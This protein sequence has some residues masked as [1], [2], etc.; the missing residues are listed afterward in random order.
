MKKIFTFVMAI[1]LTAMG[2]AQTNPPENV[3]VTP[4]SYS[5]MKI[6]WNVPYGTTQPSRLNLYN[7]ADLVTRPG[8]GY[9]GADVSATYGGQTNYGYN[10]T[11]HLDNLDNSFWIADDFTLNSSAVV[12][13]IDFFAYATGSTITSEPFTGCYVRIYDTQPVDSTAVPVW[14][15]GTV[16]CME[17]QVWSGIYRTTASAVTNTDRPIMRITANINA[18]L[19]AGTYW[20]AVCFTASSTPWMAPRS[21]VSELSTGNAIQ[22]NTNTGLWNA[23]TDNTSLEQMGIPFVVRGEFVSENLSG[24]KVYRDNVLADTALIE[25]FSFIDTGLFENT[26][27]C[28]SVEAIYSTGSPAMS[29]QE[30]TTTPEAPVD[31]CTLSELPYVQSFDGYTTGTGHFEV[32]CWNRFYTTTSTSYPYLATTHHSGNASVYMNAS[33]TNYSFI[34]APPLLSDTMVEHVTI[35]FWMKKSSATSAAAIQ[36]GVMTDPTDISTFSLIT[37]FTP[38]A[39]TDWQEA[40]IDLAGN[41]APGA[42]IT[43]K[44]TGALSYV[45]DFGIFFT[46]CMYPSTLEVMGLSTSSA[47]IAWNS[48]GASSYDFSY[49]LPLDA[50]WTDVRD[51][52]DTVYTITGLDNATAYTFD[53]RVRPICGSDMYYTSSVSFVTSCLP[54][55]APMVE[56]FEGYTAGSSGGYPVPLCWYKA[57]SVP[58]SNYPYINSS[59]TNAYSGNNYIYLYSY[60]TSTYGDN[61]LVLPA[62]TNPLNSL[63]L[64]FMARESS[65]TASY[66]GKIYVGIVT[67][68]VD[69]STFIPVDTIEPTTTTYTLFETSFAQYTGP[70]GYIAMIAPKPTTGYN[71]IYLDNL[72]VAVAGCSMPENLV[73]TQATDNSITCSWEPAAG[74]SAV[75]YTLAYLNADDPDATWVE[76]TGISDTTYT[77]MNLDENTTY[78]VKVKMLCA[79]GESAYSFEEEFMTLCTERMQVPYEENF[80]NYASLSYMDCWTRPVAYVSS[81]TLTYPSVLNSASSAHSGTNSLRFSTKNAWAATPAIDA[82]IEDLTLSF[83]A[84][85]AATTSGNMEVGVMSNPLDTST[86]ELVY[87]VTSPTTGTYQFVE[88]R[89][90]SVQTNGLNRHIAFRLN[91]TA[92]GM[93]YIDDINL[94]LTNDCPR[95]TDVTFTNITT[96]SATASW[97]TDPDVAAWNLRVKPTY[98]ETEWIEYNNLTT[99]SCI[100]TDL[101]PSTDYTVQ[102]QA[103][104]ASLSYDSYWSIDYSFMTECGII[105]TLP[106]TDNFDSYG[107]G[108]SAHPV[109]WTHNCT[110]TGTYN[111]YPYV[112]TTNFSAPASLY[113]NS[114]VQ[115]GQYDYTYFSNFAATPRIDND[116]DISA[117]AATFRLYATSTSYWMQIGFMTDSMDINTF[118]PFDTLRVSSTSTWEEKSIEFTNYTGAGRFLAFKMGGVNSTMTMYIDN[119]VLDYIPTCYKPIDFMVDSL[120]QTSIG[121]SWT[122]A[123]METQW[124]IA[125]K[126]DT[127]SVWIPITGIVD[128]FY[129]IDNLLANTTYQI[130]IKSVCGAGDESDYTDI[131]T[132]TT[133]CYALTTLPYTESFDNGAMSQTNLPMCWNKYYSGTVSNYPYINTAAGNVNTP[134]GALYMYA[135]TTYFDIAILPELDATINLSDLKL[136]F[137]AKITTAENGVQVGVMDNPL[138]PN[139]FVP[140]QTVV[141]STTSVWEDMDVYFANYTGNGHF[142][143]IKVG[144]RTRTNTVRI[145]DLVL[146]IAEPCY[147]P[148]DVTVNSISSESVEIGWYSTPNISNCEYVIGEPGFVPDTATPMSFSNIDNTIV[149]TDLQPNTSYT[150]YVRNI[151]PGGSPS[152]WSYACNFTTTCTPYQVPYI[153]D[154]D[155]DDFGSGS[156][157]EC[158]NKVGNGTLYVNN[159][160]SASYIANYLYLYTTTSTS[161]YAVL[162]EIDADINLLQLNFFAKFSNI[163][164]FFEVGIMSNP[165]DT[166]TFEYIETVN[167]RTTVWNE[168]HIPFTAYSGT[169]KFIAIRSVQNAAT[170][171]IDN[172]SVTY[173]PGCVQP[174]NIQA[175]DITTTSVSLKWR[176]GSGETQWEVA[177]GPEGFSPD[178][179]VG[180]ATSVNAY[181]DSIILTGLTPGTY[182]DV[183]VRSVCGLD[184]QSAW[185]QVFT[186]RTDCLP[187]DT[188]PYVE[189]FS[190]VSS[191]SYPLV[192]CWERKNTYSATIMYPYVSSGQLYFVSSDASYSYATT[193]PFSAN[194]NTLQVLF[195]YKAS[196][197]DYFLVVGVMSDPYDVTTFVPVDTVSSN[198]SS[199]YETKR[200][201]FNQYT[202]DGHHIAFYSHTSTYN[203]IYLD[204]V[205]VSEIPSC[206]DPEDLAATQV[207]NNSVTLNWNDPLNPTPSGYGYTV[208]YAEAGMNTYSY[209]QNVSTPPY[210]VTGLQSGTEY[211]FAV[212]R[213]CNANDSSNYSEPII[214]QTTCDPLSIPY[215]EDFDSINTAATYLTSGVLPDCWHGY[216]TLDNPAWQPHVISRN[217][218]TSY[219][220][221]NTLPNCL[222]LQANP[223]DST[224]VAL[225][226]FDQPLSNISVSFAK[227]MTTA[228]ASY[229]R[230]EV[231]YTTDPYDIDAFVSVADIVPVTSVTIDSVSFQNVANA[232]AGARIAFKWVNTYTTSTTMSYRCC[233]DDI[234]VRPIEVCE[235]PTNLSSSNITSNSATISW[236]ANGASQWEVNHKTSATSDWTTTI[237]NVPNINLT[238]LTAQTSYDVR[239]RALCNYGQ[240]P[241]SDVLTFTAEDQIVSCPDP[242]NLTATE[243]T[244]NS[245]VLEWTENG[246]ANSWI[247]NYQA[248]GENGW[249][250]SQTTD[251]PCVLTGL[252]SETTYSVFVV[253]NCETAQS[254]PSN[255]V[256]FTTLTNDIAE[257]DLTTT[258]Y[259]NPNNGR[260]IIGN[261][262][263]NIIDVNVYD[264]YGR[265]MKTVDVN[266]N[267]TEIDVSEL[268]SGIY[269][270]RI[271]TENGVV[272]KSFVKK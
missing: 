242:T 88:I 26:T 64:S 235:Q 204:N 29:S 63:V 59:T 30:C 99:N 195:D 106:F 117:L 71:I 170:V 255:T 86:F 272:T 144:D 34:V 184:E 19:A 108:S 46:D 42:Y 212:L 230:L 268:S 124:E 137:K 44:A 32:P 224:I 194:I 31:P 84:D 139:S 45:D 201:V 248:Q 203:Y 215:L 73:Q 87:T 96:T 5:Q 129:T 269:F 127:A 118:V 104:C 180:G 69:F 165:S 150:F 85:K 121:L 8:A 43:L 81:A 225:P 231:G 15:S 68:P 47:T 182:Y 11:A 38:Q 93:Y 75:S 51:I 219:A 143:A 140:V 257:Y 223:T 13:K 250:V 244:H 67:D 263:Y 158:W 36:V 253:S 176:N 141:P 167:A 142:I 24:F 234:A 246:T 256:S 200:V 146:D 145:D 152:P 50:D 18:S 260:F 189:D 173:A 60:S 105:S 259:P 171:Y 2:F 72:V 205:E 228:T 241:W 206:F 214:V 168:F 197:P 247:I 1:C 130:K 186:F 58:T 23:L 131:I 40:V 53:V 70:N 239:V 211:E 76:I 209:I 208:R 90:D 193:P 162:P 188:L 41:T 222:L 251:N 179:L 107:T 125:Y 6:T 210:T 261:E 128:T 157:P 227:R 61:Y 112:A 66:V 233:I 254:G 238:A 218:S 138:D 56:D 191:G 252:Q 100:I 169:G 163:N 37:T 217:A 123:N 258:L 74:S 80:D 14:T 267:S 164:Y 119:F 16:S 213:N 160:A 102:V 198:L 82:N 232:P 178:V 207:S 243:M 25:G 17:S 147:R 265:L 196:S 266:G 249:S 110:N 270:A 226:E 113:F 221:P 94:N 95:P 92:S 120:T 174:A 12:S 21:I 77:M 55:T 54:S 4:L 49:K 199:V 133:L 190:N 7:Q 22:Y 154:F 48:T 155:S 245:V 202:G 98:E 89:F 116:I 264:V 177:Y 10:A 166:S 20:V 271:T 122:P 109:C 3:T 78:K 103:Q 52:M 135:T 83:W 236:D 79:N 35:K 187:I 156:L 126:E 62:F 183:Y 132:S 136:S 192:H 153:H 181:E 57:N 28:Y 114:G 111:Y 115:S 91:T 185:S 151:C 9:E 220:Y 149:L 240:S 229:V 262:K 175:T 161:S 159:T 39:N 65:T 216:S 134:P 97:P 237:V 148:L 33:S 101:I 27:Y 172:L